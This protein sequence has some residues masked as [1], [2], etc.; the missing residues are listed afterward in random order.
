M[1]FLSSDELSIFELLDPGSARR[2]V[3]GRTGRA[4][5]WDP[6]ASTTEVPLAAAR[7]LAAQGI[8]DT[9][10]R[11]AAE[12]LGLW[13]RRGSTPRLPQPRRPLQNLTPEPDSAGADSLFERT[14]PV[15][16]TSEGLR[17]IS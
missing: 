12:H 1:I 7:S 4:F 13:Q 16:Q 6:I 9:K 10:G 3:I 11:I 2:L 17:A 5:V 14:L 15:G 8:V